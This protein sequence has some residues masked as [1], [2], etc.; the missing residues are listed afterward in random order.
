MLMILFNS[1]FNE[2][3]GKIPKLVQRALEKGSVDNL[4]RKSK[5]KITGLDLKLVNVPTP[6]VI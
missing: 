1:L 5:D 4:T 2:R 3:T 6:K